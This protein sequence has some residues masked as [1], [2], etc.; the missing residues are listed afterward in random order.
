VE[1][2]LLPVAVDPG[3]APLDVLLEALRWRKRD[4]EIRSREGRHRLHFSNWHA[5]HRTVFLSSRCGATAGSCGGG[6][7]TLAGKETARV[8]VT[9]DA[10]SIGRG[11]TGLP[12]GRHS[13]QSVR[14]PALYPCPRDRETG[15]GEGDCPES[16]GRGPPG[17][18]RRPNDPLGQAPTT[19]PAA[20]AIGGAAAAGSGPTRLTLRDGWGP[21]GS[22]PHPAAGG[23]RDRC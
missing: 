3:H 15:A 11:P 14:R 1:A 10:H 5:V 22:D 17:D 18:R 6:R 8:R 20:A 9:L 13:H 19:A 7:R 4:R 16:A 21:G 12:V 23:R 2:D